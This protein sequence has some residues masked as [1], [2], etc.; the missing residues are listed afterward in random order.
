MSRVAFVV[1]ASMVL[2]TIVLAITTIFTNNKWLLIITGVLAIA[3][4]LI[5]IA[6]TITTRDAF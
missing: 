5:T 3:T 2:T 6:T 1:V 4:A